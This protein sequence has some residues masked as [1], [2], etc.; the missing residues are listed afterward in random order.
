MLFP[1]PVHCFL[2][3]LVYQKSLISIFSATDS[4]LL[5]HSLHIN[6]GREMGIVLV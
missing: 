1:Q 6:G 4:P 3:F 5:V 2:I